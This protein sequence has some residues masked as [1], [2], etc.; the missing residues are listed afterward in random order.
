MISI[1]IYENALPL[2]GMCCCACLELAD[3]QFNDIS[4]YLAQFTN[5]MYKKGKYL[6]TNCIYSS[7]CGKSV[8]L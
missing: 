6:L 8:R 7:D 1:I 3:Y 5:T 4:V 2:V